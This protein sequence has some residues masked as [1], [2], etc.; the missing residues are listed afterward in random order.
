[1]EIQ[2]GF[3]F[4]LFQ[5]EMISAPTETKIEIRTTVLALPTRLELFHF[6]RIAPIDELSFYYRKDSDA[7]CSLSPN[8]IIPRQRQVFQMNKTLIPVFFHSDKIAAH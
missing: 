4:E 3:S 6:E 5:M 2:R 8:F 7:M 1:V